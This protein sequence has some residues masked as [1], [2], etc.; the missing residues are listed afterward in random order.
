M[1]LKNDL[2]KVMVAY[3][4]TLYCQLRIHTNLYNVTSTLLLMTG[5]S[6]CY[7]SDNSVQW[8]KKILVTVHIAVYTVYFYQVIYL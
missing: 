7:L 6:Q 5:R 2:R 3:F 8:K 1:G 4:K